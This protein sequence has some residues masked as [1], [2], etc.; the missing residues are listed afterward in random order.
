[1]GTENLYNELKEIDSNLYARGIFSSLVRESNG[2]SS[3]EM[4]ESFKSDLPNLASAAEVVRLY[5]ERMNLDPVE[6]DILRRG[7]L[8]ALRGLKEMIDLARLEEMHEE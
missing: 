2:A 8:I 4:H 3:L 6:A 5:A 1:M 7:A